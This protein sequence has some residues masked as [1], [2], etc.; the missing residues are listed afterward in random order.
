MLILHSKEKLEVGTHQVIHLVGKC[1][2]WLRGIQLCWV[3]GAGG[4]ALQ[5]GRAE[6][7]TQCKAKR[8]PRVPSAGPLGHWY[9]AVKG[10]NYVTA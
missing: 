7:C 4:T 5:A 9:R 1:S 3:G 10:D 8:A 6:P 2:L